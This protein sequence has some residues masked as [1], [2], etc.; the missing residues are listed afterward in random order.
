MVTESAS[1]G[2]SG[3]WEAH[4]LGIWEL[5]PRPADHNV[6]GSI[7]SLLSQSCAW[8]LQGITGRTVSCTHGSWMNLSSSRRWD[9]EDHGVI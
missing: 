2:D 1:S 4:P 7:P 8:A 5:G 3:S 6:L 9:S